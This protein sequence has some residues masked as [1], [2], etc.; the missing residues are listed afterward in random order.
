MRHNKINLP[1]AFVRF[2]LT[3]CTKRAYDLATTLELSNNK[4]KVQFSDFN[5]RSHNILGDLEN[6]DLTK[7]NCK[8]LF[9]AFS[10]NTQLPDRKKI[11]EIFQKFGK[12][13]AIWMRQ[14]EV[15]TKYR[16]HFF[17]DYKYHEEAKKALEELFEDDKLGQKR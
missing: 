7:E 3:S 5:K 14:T 1:Y 10:V 17:V 12:I 2:K 9:I 13:R 6:Y 15:N 4:L 8:T 11:N 16:P